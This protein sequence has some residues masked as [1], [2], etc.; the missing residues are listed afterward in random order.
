MTV[1]SLNEK[2]KSLLEATFMH[3]AVEG[4]VSSV[5]YHSSGH[6]YF[7]I[8]DERS[9]LRC[10]MW[11]SNV[12]RLRFR[13]EKGQRIVV[14]G[15]VGVY[16]PRGEYQLI[17]VGVEP[18]GQGALALA[19]EQ[20]K[21]KLESKGY[22]APERKQSIP[23]YPMRIALVTAAQGA[24]LHDM[25][26]IARR[27]WPLAEFFVIDVPVQGEGAAAEIARGIAYADGLGVDVIVTGRGGGSV[28][29]LW[30]FN[31]EAVADAIHFARTPVVSAVGHEVDTLIS[32][33]VAD[34]RAPT[35]SAAME[36]IL[37]DRNELLLDLDERQERF[38]RRMAEI[39]AHARR[40]LRREEEA[41][42]SLSVAS[43]LRR[44]AERFET[45]AA[46]LGRAVTFRLER[47][48][49]ELVPLR[50]RIEEQEE[51]NLRRAWTRLEDLGRALER[52]NPALRM[53]E[54]WAEVTRDGKRIPLEKL[55]I[56]ER[57]TLT[58]GVRRVEAEC[59][60]N[61]PLKSGD[62]PPK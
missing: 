21:R 44:S 14:T 20:L 48:G 11:R 35:P 56:G 22:F 45:L 26:K 2:I 50:R 36:L 16:T 15:S 37:P 42:R 27:R 55:R 6:L 32:D 8:K 29:D 24:A 38:R 47:S 49:S 60:S 17:A 43:R 23:P 52:H 7:S 1:S 34:L 51:Q 57:F 59:L 58:D 53:R 12:S 41:L 54:G 18:S 5:T 30:A 25:L 61:E 31:E 46:E 28:E 40:A 4:E 9:V 3:V 62:H 19:F 33:F 39:L 10:V 13:L